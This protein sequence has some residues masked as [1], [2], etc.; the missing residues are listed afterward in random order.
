MEALAAF[1]IAC[2]VMQV[3]SFSKDAISL[4][5]QVYKEGASVDNQNLAQL[6]REIARAAENVQS[7]L[8]QARQ[9]NRQMSPTEFQLRDVAGQCLATAKSLLDKLDG[10]QK[11]GS[12]RLGPAL[13]K[14]V[15]TIR[16][17]SSLKKLEERLSA[18]QRILG[19][20]LLVNL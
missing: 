9:P 2:N 19:M 10:L 20:S 13:S 4:S 14:S 6:S 3:I 15:K 16:L 5:L 11:A 8:G 12:G 17:R 1:G 7:Q 18:N